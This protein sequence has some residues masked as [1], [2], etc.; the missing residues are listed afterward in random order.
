V[1]GSR[2]WED[3]P[4]VGAMRSPAMAA[5]VWVCLALAACGNADAGQVRVWVQNSGSNE[6]FVFAPELF[7]QVK[8][9]PGAFGIAYAGAGPVEAT[10]DIIG[11]ECVGLGLVP[12]SATAGDL[13]IRVS[14]A[15]P[16]VSSP[17]FLELPW[18]GQALPEA[19]N[20]S[21]PAASGWNHDGP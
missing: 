15:A 3:R 18:D 1:S 16:A 7:V 4:Q 12:I 11:P 19:P 5:A 6:A 8:A 9:R 14:D 20:S 2:W 10:F 21:C 17:G 13:V